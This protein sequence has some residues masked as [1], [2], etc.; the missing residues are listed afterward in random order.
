MSGT[1]KVDGKDINR[2][3]KDELARKMAVVLTEQASPLMTTAFEI[4][5]MGRYP[6]TNFW[7]S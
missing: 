5:A 2:M 4:A 3:K 6:H 1:V 7:V